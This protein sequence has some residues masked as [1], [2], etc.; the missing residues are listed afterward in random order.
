MADRNETHTVKTQID[1]RS[2]VQM[3]WLCTIQSGNPDEVRR[4]YI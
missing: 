1:C 4:T 2:L 3:T